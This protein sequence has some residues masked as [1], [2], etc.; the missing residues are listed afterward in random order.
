MLV[1][2]NDLLI[3]QERGRDLLEQAEAHRMHKRCAGKQLRGGHAGEVTFR[4][5]RWLGIQFVAVGEGMQRR[6]AS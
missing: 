1:S 5:L 2:Y 3:A 6:Y 4:T